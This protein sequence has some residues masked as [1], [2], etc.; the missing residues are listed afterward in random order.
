MP[1]PH[2]RIYI[3]TETTG[4][5]PNVHELLEVAMVIEELPEPA[6]WEDAIQTWGRK[7]L[8][9]RWRGRFQSL[10]HAVLPSH[11]K[12]G[13]ITRKWAQKIKPKH[14]ETATAKAL[15]V[16]KYSPEEW[17]DAVDFNDIAQ[18]V[19]NTLSQKG[20]T[21]IGSNPKFD[22]EF[23]KRACKEAGIKVEDKFFPFR[24]IDTR[25][26]AFTAWGQNGRANVGL[27]SLREY[28]D[29][30]KQGAHRALKDA[31]DAREVFYTALESLRVL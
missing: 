8:P 15:E 3:D 9:P 20:V 12:R 11:R 17:A 13:T 30:P 21:V 31:L 19:Y 24:P 5:D 14:I 23:L 18:D 16:N 22:L 26:L 25:A 2:K 4:L 7:S 1:A 6:G 10:C 28:L 29:L 27:D